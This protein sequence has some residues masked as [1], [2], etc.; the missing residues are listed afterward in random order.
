MG[1]LTIPLQN[2]MFKPVVISLLR[3]VGARRKSVKVTYVTNDVQKIIDSPI[4]KRKNSHNELDKRSNSIDLE[5]NEDIIQKGDI[6]KPIDLSHDT[7]KKIEET[8]SQRKV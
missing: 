5:Q 7:N 1:V 3:S 4:K 2:I 6:E 8:L